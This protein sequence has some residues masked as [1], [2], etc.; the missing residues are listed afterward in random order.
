[1]MR[2]VEETRFGNDPG[3]KLRRSAG[4]RSVPTPAGHGAARR[5]VAAEARGVLSV[6]SVR[7]IGEQSIDSEVFGFLH[8]GV[9]QEDRGE[10]LKS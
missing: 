1:M 3:L 7:F 6:A 4:R 2:E 9:P 10:A 5:A 8:G